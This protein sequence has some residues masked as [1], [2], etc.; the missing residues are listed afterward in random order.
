[1]LLWIFQTYFLWQILFWSVGVNF[2]LTGMM[3]QK[4]SPAKTENPPVFIF[5]FP[6]LPVPLSSPHIPIRW[7][8]DMC[9]C[10]CW[11][12][13][14]ASGVEGRAGRCPVESVTTKS[15]GR[16]V[17]HAHLSLSRPFLGAYF[18][19]LL[20]STYIL[21]LPHSCTFQNGALGWRNQDAVVLKSAS[22]PFGAL[23]SRKHTLDPYYLWAPSVLSAWFWLLWEAGKCGEKVLCLWFSRWFVNS[24]KEMFLRDEWGPYAR[25]N[26]MSN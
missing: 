16:T 8:S 14:E 7:I 19:P 20:S 2:R 17:C 24:P 5:S 18:C 22:V 10:T 12:W 11:I 15:D 26:C 6:M 23:W 4:S 9:W 13:S 3:N 25:W 1:M 21:P